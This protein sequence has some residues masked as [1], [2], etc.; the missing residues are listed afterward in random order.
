M[1]K[2]SDASMLKLLVSQYGVQEVM[3]YY[4]SKG[5][6]AANSCNSQVKNNNPVAVAQHLGEIHE[7]LSALRQIVNDKENIKAIDKLSDS[8]I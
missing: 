7:A 2:M 3:S 4:V 5:Y 6:N 8:V 1:D